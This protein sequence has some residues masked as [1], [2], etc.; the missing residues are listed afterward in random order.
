MLALTAVTLTSCGDDD[1]GNI[2]KGTKWDGKVTVEKGY[3]TFTSNLG[4][5]FTSTTYRVTA[6]IGTGMAGGNYTLSEDNKT[7]YMDAQEGQTIGKI[8]DDGKTMTLSNTATKI[9]GTLTK[10]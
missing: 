6:G 1:E 4:L 5:E 3:S 10:Q 2:L 7:V 9:S 8:S